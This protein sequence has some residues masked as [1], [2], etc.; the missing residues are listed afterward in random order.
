MKRGGDVH[1]MYLLPRLKASGLDRLVIHTQAVNICRKEL[2]S[3]RKS[4]FPL[5]MYSYLLKW[6]SILG[7]EF[8]LVLMTN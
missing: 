6:T 7:D 3:T 1:G 8:T 4:S 2:F 5:S